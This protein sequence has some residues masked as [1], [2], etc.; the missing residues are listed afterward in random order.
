[1]VYRTHSLLDLIDMQYIADSLDGHKDFTIEIGTVL[2][3]YF[4]H[5]IFS[6]FI[7]HSQ[8]VY[9]KILQLFKHEFDEEYK[10]ESPE[11]RFLFRILTMPTDDIPIDVSNSKYNC[12][13]CSKTSKIR[14]FS[15]FT[16]CIR[17]KEK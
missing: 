6:L 17:P 7:E 2:S 9:M 11:L 16:S 14:Q 10:D 3:T 8:K 12:H 13:I 1:M 4:G 5:T 15:S